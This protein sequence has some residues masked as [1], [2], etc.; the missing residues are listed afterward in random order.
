MEY[1]AMRV[2]WFFSHMPYFASAVFFVVGGIKLLFADGD[3]W[4]IVSL[5]P[6]NCVKYA[7]IVATKNFCCWLW[8]L[9]LCNNLNSC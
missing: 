7:K 5:C 4:L 9:L 1:G 6:G 2:L 8:I 3:T